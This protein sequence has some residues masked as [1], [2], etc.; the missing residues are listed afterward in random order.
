MLR[1]FGII[2]EKTKDRR[3]KI[4]FK[5]GKKEK[6]H[7]SPTFEQKFQNKTDI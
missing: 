6:K 7:G 3:Q 5:T 1:L 2:K 4:C